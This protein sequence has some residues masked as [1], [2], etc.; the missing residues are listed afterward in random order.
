[1]AHLPITLAAQ[2]TTTRAALFIFMGAAISTTTAGQ[3]S[4]TTRAARLVL[5]MGY[6]HVEREQYRVLALLLVLSQLTQIARRNIL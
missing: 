6:Q 4:I 5:P 2:S 3:L 1:L